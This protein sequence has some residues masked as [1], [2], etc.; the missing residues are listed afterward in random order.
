M[1]GLDPGIHVPPHVDV[2]GEASACHTPGAL[3]G[4]TTWIPGSSPG[5]TNGEGGALAETT[6]TDC[7]RLLKTGTRPPL[8]MPGLDPGIHVP[9]HVDVVGEGGRHFTPGAL[10]GTT[11]WIPGS[12]PGM[13]NGGV[14]L[15]T[16]G[17][18][19]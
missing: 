10:P 4:T 2:V 11:T 16:Q 1:P 18:S 5:M 12:S 3:P 8:V 15:K 13:T 7:S 9:P 14:A 19:I 17:A 6:H